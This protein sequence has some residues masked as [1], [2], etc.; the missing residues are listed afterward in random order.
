MIKHS[1]TIASAAALLAALAW[2]ITARAEDQAQPAETIEAEQTAVAEE[3]ASAEP[4]SAPEPQIAPESAVEEALA[5]E[6]AAAIDE[7]AAEK[8][9]A[10]EEAAAAIDEPAAEK[11]LAEEE[12]AAAVD[13]PAAEKALAEEEAAAAVDEP[14]AEEALVEEEAT[15]AAQEPGDA[16]A[17]DEEVNFDDIPFFNPE[18]TGT[19]EETATPEQAA[20]EPSATEAAVSP[21]ASTP[22]HRAIEKSVGSWRDES[23]LINSILAKKALLAAGGGPS[24][25][26]SAAKPNDAL[27]LSQSSDSSLGALDRDRMLTSDPSALFDLRSD[28]QT[29]PNAAPQMRA[30]QIPPQQNLGLEGLD[31]EPAGPMPELPQD[32]LAAGDIVACD[33]LTVLPIG[34]G[35]DATVSANTQGKLIELGIEQKDAEG[36]PVLDANG[37]PTV[38]PL[39]RGMMVRAGDVLGKQFNQEFIARKEAA[40]RQLI[41][42]EKEAGKTLEIEVAELAALVA[43]SELDRVRQA[44][45]DMPGAIAEEDEVKRVYEYNRAYKSW[46]KAKYDLGIKAD[47][48]EV[49]KAEILIADAQLEERKL[50]SPIEGQ[51]DDIYQNEGQWLREG[52]KV[53]RVIRLDKIQVEARFDASKTSPDAVQGKKATIYASRPGEQTCQ[54][55]GVVTYAR[56]IIQ[57]TRVAAFI[58]ADNGKTEN[59]SWYLIP[60]MHVQVV[61]HP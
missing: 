35:Y 54:F 45:R 59:G 22:A 31:T 7:P 18:G 48:V 53:F 39:R 40:Q 61:V 29:A 4:A 12:A 44:N 56:P 23:A 24:T 57:H 9:L 34:E 47:E 26:V 42:A 14:A 20:A 30:P 8:A 10:E 25:T 11:A 60:G 58:E 17:A 55:E 33:A 28:P 52:G 15:A 51:I 41:V 38:T 43:K 3:P 13:E 5:E 1:I 27:A 50:I 6:E 32:K 36:N 37:H 46:E 19:P 2:G 49:R 21:A 16:L